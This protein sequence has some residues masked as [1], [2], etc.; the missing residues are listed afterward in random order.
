MIQFST[1]VRQFAESFE[2]D[3][4]YEMGKTIADKK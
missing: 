2:T 1:P 3:R 4:K